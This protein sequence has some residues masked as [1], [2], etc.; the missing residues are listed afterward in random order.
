MAVDCLRHLAH[1][2]E[3]GSCRR[4]KHWIHLSS[5][6][7]RSYPLTFAITPEPGK[8]V[9]WTKV[10][11]RYVGICRSYQ[12][13][14]VHHTGSLAQPQQRMIS[15]ATAA[16]SGFPFSKDASATSALLPAHGSAYASTT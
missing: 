15:N 12:G 7:L 8:Q 1:L 2:Q 10:L 3:S 13:S 9:N 6:R 16:V 4:I 11:N 14:P 5:V